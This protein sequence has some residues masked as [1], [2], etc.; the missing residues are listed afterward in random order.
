MI[1]GCKNFSSAEMFLHADPSISPATPF[2]CNF[3]IY[4]TFSNLFPPLVIKTTFLAL[5]SVKTNILLHLFLCSYSR[6][7]RIHGHLFLTPTSPNIT[8]SFISNKYF[9]LMRFKAFLSET[10]RMMSD[11]NWMLKV[12]LNFIKRSDEEFQ[13]VQIHLVVQDLTNP[14]TWF[15]HTHFDF[16]HLAA[17]V[18]T[19]RSGCAAQ[20]V[21]I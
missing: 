7:G 16:T 13:R 10:S 6:E 1:H 5:F 21:R 2:S 18:S 15:S 3:T 12:V 14:Q 4:D 8:F 9:K 19:E 11:L 17:T 20:Y